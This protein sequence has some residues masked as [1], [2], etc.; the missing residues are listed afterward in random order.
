MMLLLWVVTALCVCVSASNCQ[1]PRHRLWLN[2]TD[3]R[4]AG[5]HFRGIVCQLGTRHIHS[6]APSISTTSEMKSGGTQGVPRYNPVPGKL[7][8]AHRWSRLG[9]VGEGRNCV[10]G[11]LTRLIACDWRELNGVQCEIVHT[12]PVDCRI[13]VK[14]RMRGVAACHRHTMLAVII[15]ANKCGAHISVRALILCL[16]CESG[17]R[18][19]TFYLLTRFGYFWNHIN[20]IL[21]H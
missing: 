14:R 2:L 1:K 18:S 10:F 3:V 20:Q 17:Q 8:A 12:V 5:L 21:Y 15:N 19:N 13:V 7:V 6:R 11:G 16:W 9:R 4:A